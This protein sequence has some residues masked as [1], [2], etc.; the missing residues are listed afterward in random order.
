MINYDRVLEAADRTYG[1]TKARKFG[2]DPAYMAP[3]QFH[4]I[5]SDQIKAICEALVDAVNQEL[6]RLELI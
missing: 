4:H 2:Q 5:E 1:L 6:Q 3:E